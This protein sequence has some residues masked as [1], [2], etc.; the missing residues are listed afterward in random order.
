[1]KLSA[2]WQK[3]YKWYCIVSCLL[4]ALVGLLVPLCVTRF[5]VTNE[6]LYHIAYHL[7]RILLMATFFGVDL[8]LWIISVVVLC[9]RQESMSCWAFCGYTLLMLVLKFMNV[10]SWVAIT[11]GV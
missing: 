6:F 5:D 1:M 7:C 2:K 4:A 8:I 10:I 11:G 9:F 3:L